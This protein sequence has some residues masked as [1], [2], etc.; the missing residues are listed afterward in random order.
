M[1][2]RLGLGKLKGKTLFENL[3]TIKDPRVER[4]RTA[5]VERYIGDCGVCDDLWSGRLGRYGGIW[6]R[7]ER[8]VLDIFGIRK[9][10]SQSRHLSASIYLVG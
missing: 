2:E 3:E 6:G 4:T 9:R 10:N 7:Q 1:G 8:M 5:F